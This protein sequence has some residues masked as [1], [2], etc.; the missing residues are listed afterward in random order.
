MEG[1]KR[2]AEIYNEA[3][4]F[5]QANGLR[6]GLHNHWWELEDV[7]GVGQALLCP[8]AI[9]LSRR[10]F[11]RLTPIGPRLQA[12][13]QHRWWRTLVPVCHFCT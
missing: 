8:A 12:G 11:S 6:F 10:Y 4:A 7:P 3:L 13:I 2:L 5:A 9:L 1:I